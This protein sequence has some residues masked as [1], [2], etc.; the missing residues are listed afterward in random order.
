MP[1]QDFRLRAV[2]L[3]QENTPTELLSSTAPD[4]SRAKTACFFSL[5][6]RAKLM[7]PSYYKFH[8]SHQDGNQ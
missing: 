1:I 4:S 5:R 8:L 3:L 6:R 2:D 7:S